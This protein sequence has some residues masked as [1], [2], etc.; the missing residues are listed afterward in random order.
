MSDQYKVQWKG[1]TDEKGNDSTSG[2]SA[3][4]LIG[5]VTSVFD[6]W[7]RTPSWKK[8]KQACIKEIPNSYA[9]FT[10]AALKGSQIT[11][12]ASVVFCTYTSQATVKSRSGITKQGD[13]SNRIQRKMWNREDKFTV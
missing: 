5:S 2:N 12:L 9:G 13:D 8:L 1:W 10:E 3:D 11:E 4:Y 6:F 7:G